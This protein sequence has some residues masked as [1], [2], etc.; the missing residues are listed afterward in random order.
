MSKS[1]EHARL[2]MVKAAEDLYVLGRLI[3]DDSAPLAAI[4]F[5]AQ[6]AVEKYLKAVL[7]KR[8]VSYARTHDIAALL[9]LLTKNDIGAPPPAAAELR[10]LT[11][12]AAAFR[13]DELPAEDDST[14][15]LDRA[16]ILQCV[17]Q[18]KAWAQQLLG[19]TKQSG[20]EPRQ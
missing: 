15:P 2:L 19:D 9:K 10:S 18:V 14:P 16:G 1:C 17:R 5:H 8:E 4:G 20:R 3:E 13:Y 6:Q 11:P 7:A 12:F